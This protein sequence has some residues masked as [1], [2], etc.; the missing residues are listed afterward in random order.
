[1]SWNVK[2]VGTNAGKNPRLAEDVIVNFGIA[3]P[4]SAVVIRNPLKS[5]FVELFGPSE[6]SATAIQA[7]AIYRTPPRY[8]YLVSPRPGATLRLALLACRD[9]VRA[10]SRAPV[11]SGVKTR[12]PRWFM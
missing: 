6:R 8:R 7:A 3:W 1:M 12:A 2:S 11:N 4:L 5:A 10:A 9:V